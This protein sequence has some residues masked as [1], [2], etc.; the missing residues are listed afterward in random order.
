MVACLQV[1]I[2]KS[3]QLQGC[4]RVPPARP[5]WF[6]DIV[7]YALGW[8]VGSVTHWMLYSIN[9]IVTQVAMHMLVQLGQIAPEVQ[10]RLL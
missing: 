9:I 6:A 10:S 8:L 5:C 1:S 4:Y 7:I 2:D 3:L